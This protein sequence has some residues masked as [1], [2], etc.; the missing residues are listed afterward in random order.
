[1]EDH[2]ADP[3]LSVCLSCVMQE[4]KE[5]STCGRRGKVVLYTTSVKAV[6][7][8]QERCKQVTH[9]LRSHRIPF[10]SKDVFLHPDYSKELADRLG[11]L[12]RDIPLPQVSKISQYPPK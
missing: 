5:D 12:P 4:E 1:M 9:T 6:R 11:G 10:V 8:T 7:S 3:F 2:A